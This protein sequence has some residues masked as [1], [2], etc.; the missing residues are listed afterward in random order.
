MNLPDITGLG[1]A[2]ALVL[3]VAY[4]LIQFQKDRKQRIEDDIADQAR[5]DKMQARIDD[6]TTKIDE[7]RGLR[8]AAEDRE[9][10]YRREVAALTVTVENLTRKL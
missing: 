5:V 10:R 6:L 3:I 2:G 8:R 7:E 9:D 1:I 4:L